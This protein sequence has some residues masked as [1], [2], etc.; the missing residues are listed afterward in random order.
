MI[1]H[2]FQ[3]CWQCPEKHE[4]PCLAV[5]MPTPLVTRE[6]INDLHFFLP[7]SSLSLLHWRKLPWQSSCIIKCINKVKT[8]WG[9]F[10]CFSA[11]LR[12]KWMEK[13]YEG[14]FEAAD[15]KLKIE[16]IRGCQYLR[17]KLLTGNS[18]VT[19]QNNTGEI[20]EEAWAKCSA[21]GHVQRSYHPT[22]EDIIPRQI[23]GASM[24]V[25]KLICY[26]NPL[27][28]RLESH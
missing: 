9:R 26:L 1:Q 17:L 19:Y 20:T 12:K 13:L 15:L 25:T 24:R 14:V 2:V 7:F 23:Q 10:Y 4:K 6:I 21:F 27:A 28:P 8:T 18:S 11:T 16:L 22:V 5:A 3:H